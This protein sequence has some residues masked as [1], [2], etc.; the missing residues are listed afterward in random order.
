[1]E[2]AVVNDEP[3][4][5]NDEPILTNEDGAGRFLGNVSKKHLYNLRKR[6]LLPYV[7]VGQRVMYKISSLREFARTHERRAATAD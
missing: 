1:M 5:T 2:S 3:I 4:L 7:M 6:G